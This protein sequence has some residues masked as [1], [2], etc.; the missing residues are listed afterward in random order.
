MTFTIAAVVRTS[1]KVHIHYLF[2]C[3]HNNKPIVPDGHFRLPAQRVD[4]M[5]ASRISRQDSP[6]NPPSAATLV[7]IKHTLNECP[8]TTRNLGLCNMPENRFIA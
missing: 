3:V 8:E 7:S 6:P 1:T 4:P 2:P 5:P